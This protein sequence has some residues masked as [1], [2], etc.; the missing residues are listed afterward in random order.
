MNTKSDIT[1]IMFTLDIKIE[2]SNT[3]IPEIEIISTGRL[4]ADVVLKF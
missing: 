4:S 3:H 1:S 2:P